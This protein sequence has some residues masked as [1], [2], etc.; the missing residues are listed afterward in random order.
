MDPNYIIY[1]IFVMVGLVI[2]YLANVL[3]K[4]V[5][6]RKIQNHAHVEEHGAIRHEIVVGDKKLELRIEVLEKK[7]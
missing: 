2:I 7:T 3:R 5:H 6:R 1:S 4:E